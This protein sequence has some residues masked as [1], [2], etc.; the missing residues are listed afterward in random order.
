MYYRDLLNLSYLKIYPELGIPLTEEDRV[1]N[2]EEIFD[3]SSPTKRGPPEPVPPAN[4]QM[5]HLCFILKGVLLQKNKKTG[6]VLHR[7]EEGSVFC[8]DAIIDIHTP[9]IS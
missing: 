4:L 2:E 3:G 9:L 6:K 8:N 5:T 7:F 1:F